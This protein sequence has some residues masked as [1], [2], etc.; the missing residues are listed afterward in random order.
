MVEQRTL[1]PL[2]LVRIQVPQPALSRR[3]PVET[4]I[5]LT[6]RSCLDPRSWG[7]RSRFELPN[8]R[9]RQ[10]DIAVEVKGV[11]DGPHVPER[12][13]GDGR[14]LAFRGAGQEQPGHGVP[15]RYSV[16]RCDG[17]C[18]FLTRQEEDALW[19]ACST[20]APERRRAFGR[21]P[22]SASVVPGP[23]PPVRR[24]PQ[25]RPEVAQA[26]HHG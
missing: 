4:S 16:P 26:D 10:R 14:D 23:C 18:S 9:F 15:R 22:R 12:V 13:P 2:I 5:A 25:D 17:A 24:R 3:S 1:T 8:A 21:A 6:A 19:Q 7:S 11:E 20:V